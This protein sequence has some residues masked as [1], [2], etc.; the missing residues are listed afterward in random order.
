MG[1][2]WIEMRQ[3]DGTFVGRVGKNEPIPRGYW[4]LQNCIFVTPGEFREMRE[5]EF[6]CYDLMNGRLNEYEL[7]YKLEQCLGIGKHLP[8]PLKVIVLWWTDYLPRVYGSE[9]GIARIGRDY[10][11]VLSGVVTFEDIVRGHSVAEERRIR[12][13]MERLS[14]EVQTTTKK[15]A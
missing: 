12:D 5:L 7:W 6:K 11:W 8:G 10:I 13:A 9:K 14:S 4:E 2:E 1:V 15:S 3:V